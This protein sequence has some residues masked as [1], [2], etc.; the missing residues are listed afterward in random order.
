MVRYVGKAIVCVVIGLQLG[1]VTASAA[2][3]A[4]TP[5]TGL[6]AVTGGSCAGGAA[7]GSYFRMILPTGNRQ[8]PFISNSDSAC[9][10]KTFTLLA[11]GSDGGLLAGSYQPAPAPAF[12]AGGNGLAGRVTAPTKFFGVSFAT[13]TNASDPQTGV[14]VPPPTV[15]LNPDGTLGGDLRSF[16]ASWNNQDFNQ[17]APKPDGSLTGNTAIPTGT[18]DAASG[19][20]TLEWTSQIAGG[21]FDQFTGLW[22]LEGRYR[23]AGA[24]PA[25]ALPGGA[26]TAAGASTAKGTTA[27]ATTAAA[28]SD[29]GSA[30]ASSDEAA[31]AAEEATASVNG[32]AA[33]ST[34]THK[35]SRVSTWLVLLTALL[36]LLATGGFFYLDRAIRT[37]GSEA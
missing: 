31:A 21:P 4:A 12:D 22:H 26:S 20:F 5:V 13:S 35:D 1:A 16:A 3:A 36:G 17:G 14:A 11:P 24:P 33:S 28:S 10:D 2:P 29:A 25:G 9:A 30:S 34:T 8:G 19:A 27:G 37:R 6:L 23:N 18:Y 32:V 7:S 15:S